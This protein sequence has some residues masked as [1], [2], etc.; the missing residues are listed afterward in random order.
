[1]STFPQGQESNIKADVWTHIAVSLDTL[2]EKCKVALFI[3]GNQIVNNPIA[4]P[5]KEKPTGN[6]CYEK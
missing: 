6:R 1:M 5:T 4:A 3:N 2:G